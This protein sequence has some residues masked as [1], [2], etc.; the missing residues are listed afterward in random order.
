LNKRSKQLAIIWL[1][2]CRLS[3]DVDL[4]F[5]YTKVTYDLLHQ[6]ELD[7]TDS[8]LIIYGSVIYI[9]AIPWNTYYYLLSI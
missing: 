4:N 1:V 7:F 2:A 5:M 9:V 3:F 6:I 8:F